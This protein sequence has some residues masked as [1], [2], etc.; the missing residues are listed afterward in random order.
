MVADADVELIA[1]MVREWNSGD[2]EAL[3]EVFDPEV[4]V[5]PALRTFLAATVYRGH[6][7]VRT[8][9]EE[10]NEPWAELHAEPERFAKDGERT[11]VVL[12]LRAR[13]PGGR[14][15]VDAEIAHV[16]T[17]RDGRIVRLDGYENPATALAELG[18]EQTLQER[19]PGVER[20]AAIPPAGRQRP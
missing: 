5:R 15:D 6:D 12:A 3:L 9:F 19:T 14:V 11:L 20:D 17:I 8:W 10:S 13:V 4:E 18:L 1:R 16:V 2:V 7:G